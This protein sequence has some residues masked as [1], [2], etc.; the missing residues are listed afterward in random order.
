LHK[1]FGLSQA[2]VKSSKY[3]KRYSEKRENVKIFHQNEPD[4]KRQESYLKFILNSSTSVDVKIFHHFPKQ[5][6]LIFQNQEILM[7]SLFY[8]LR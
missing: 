7:K 2:L 1:N 8:Y 3:E 6:I 4:E 5:K